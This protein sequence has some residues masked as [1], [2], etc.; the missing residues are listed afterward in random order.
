MSVSELCSVS[1]MILTRDVDHEGRAKIDRQL[2]PIDM[3]MDSALLPEG[4]RGVQPPSWWSTE[5]A[6]GNISV[7]G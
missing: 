6:S 7:D 3:I 2:T 1:Y 4:L 5:G